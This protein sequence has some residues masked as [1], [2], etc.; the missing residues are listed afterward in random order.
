MLNRAFVISNSV[1]RSVNKTQHLA[2]GSRLERPNRF[3]EGFRGQQYGKL[4]PEEV[5]LESQFFSTFSIF[6][7]HGPTLGRIFG[8]VTTCHE[9][10]K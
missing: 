2:H 3:R 8:H 6:N 7:F 10:V 4:S 9:G 1:Y 5:H